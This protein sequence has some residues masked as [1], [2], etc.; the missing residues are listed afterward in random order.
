MD[1]RACIDLIKVLEDGSP[2]WVGR[3][4]KIEEAHAKLKELGSA[5]DDAFLA[6]DKSTRSVVAHVV[7]KASL[8]R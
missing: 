7:G 4:A 2:F 5:S 3:V 1:T 8:A 6:I